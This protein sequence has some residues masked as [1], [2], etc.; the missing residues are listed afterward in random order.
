M[1]SLL[2]KR[3]KAT[4]ALDIGS[5]VVKCLRLDHSGE[6]PLITNFAMVEL[7]PDAI[8][9]GEIMDREMVVEAIRECLNQANVSDADV[10]TSIG[11]RSVIVKKIIMDKMAAADAEE[12][13][14]WEAEQHVPFDIDDICLDFQIVKEDVGANQME[15]L[16]VA[17]KKETIQAH[18]ELVREADMRPVLI[19]VDAFAVQNA[20]E[21]NNG[22]PSDDVVGL[23]NVGADVTSLCVVQSGTPY[24]TRD[25]NVGTNRLVEEFQKEFGVSFDEARDFVAHPEKVEES[26]ADRLVEIVRG[27]AQDLSMGI[28]RSI[29]Y[30]RTSG[31]A[32]SID[33]IVLSGGGARFPGLRQL[34]SEHDN[35][36]IEIGNPLQCVGYDADVFGDENV[37]ELAPLLTVSVGLGLRSQGDKQ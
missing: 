13:I 12:A 23:M 11:G 17:A 7:M 36:E 34:L 16:L 27:V 4:V 9:E 6:Q 5:N 2:R 29:S 28:D 31:D 20:W 26:E 33:R 10:S 22:G 21:M 15:I 37:D 35:Y 18:A 25:L 14:F 30:L 24:F 32:E 1:I 19:D 8:V 3:S